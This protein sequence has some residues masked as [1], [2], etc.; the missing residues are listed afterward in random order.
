MTAAMIGNTS[1][2]FDLEILS[3][4][5]NLAYLPKP[6]PLPRDE[7]IQDL[8]LRCIENRTLMALQRRIGED[9]A[10]VLHA[11]AERM[12]SAQDERNSQP[13]AR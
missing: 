12:A 10:M 7:E 1:A 9:Q 13:D 8:L 5:R 3:L 4:E 6:I 11:F 2:D